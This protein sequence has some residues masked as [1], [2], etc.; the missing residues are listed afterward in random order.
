[1]EEKT[2][3]LSIPA[4]APKRELRGRTLEKKESG[5]MR[6]LRTTKERVGPDQGRAEEGKKKKKSPANHK[7]S[8]QYSMGREQV[9]W[10]QRR[11]KKKVTLS[12]RF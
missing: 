9:L 6:I 3:I 4:S 11:I 7:L 5:E 10:Q 8:P 2:S 1:M 12:L